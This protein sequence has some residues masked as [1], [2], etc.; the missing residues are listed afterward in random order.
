M[1]TAREAALGVFNAVRSMG[2]GGVRG[3]DMRDVEASRLAT[4]D[5]AIGTV[6]RALDGPPRC[7][8]REPDDESLRVM[9]AALRERRQ[10]LTTT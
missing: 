6:Q 4:V 1:L 3:A 7:L 9:L 8:C 5:R 2:T 10:A